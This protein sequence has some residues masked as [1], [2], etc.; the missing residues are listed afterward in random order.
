MT[1]NIHFRL[2]DVL[3]ERYRAEGSWDALAKEIATANHP[4]SKRRVDRRK[5]KRLCEG[6]EDVYL[7]VSELM[8]INQYLGKFREGL[9]EK[10]IFIRQED[11]LDSVSEAD[12][13]VIFVAARFDKEW[14]TDVVSRWD[15]RAIALL[16][17]SKLVGKDIDIHDVLHSKGVKKIKEK[18]A[19]WMDRLFDERAKI[20]IGSPIACPASEYL[21][22]H[23]LGRNPYERTAV[24]QGEQLP[25]YFVLPEPKIAACPS[26]FF[27]SRGEATPLLQEKERDILKKMDQDARAMIVQNR[28]FI[29]TW[30]GASYG[31]LLAQRQ[32]RGQVAMVLSG[33]FGPS[34]LS[35]ARVLVQHQIKATLP[36]FN[37]QHERQPILIAVVEG[38]TELR[39]SAKSKRD[40]PEEENRWLDVSRVVMHPELLYFSEGRWGKPDGRRGASKEAQM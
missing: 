36:P 39:E 14:K 17:R 32:E 13:V 11:L 12:K 6:A 15:T 10:P 20:C 37:A 33:T 35:I 19:E 7:S 29:S 27:L 1:E 2:I 5:L 24:N 21:M 30:I 4:H 40:M 26:T 16:N 28:L 3:N 34:T 18:S 38:K 31:L 22:A 23:I 8:A 9:D 25:F